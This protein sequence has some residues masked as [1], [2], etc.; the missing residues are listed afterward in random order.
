MRRNRWLYPIPFILSAIC[1]FTLLAREAVPI[2]YRWEVE[3]KL[4]FVWIQPTPPFLIDVQ[5]KFFFSEIDDIRLNAAQTILRFPSNPRLDR[6]SLLVA[7]L[8]RLNE[9]EPNLT[10]EHELLAAACLLDDG[11]RSD[12][13]WQ[14]ALKSPL[15]QR[16]V[17]RALVRWH[18]PEALSIWR[19]RIADANTP[20]HDLLLA[21]Q[22][23]GEVGTEEDI[24]SLRALALSGIQNSEVRIAAAKSIGQLGSVVDL[25]LAQK[26]RQAKTEFADYLA[27][28]AVPRGKRSNDGYPLPNQETVGFMTALANSESQIAQ[29]AAYAW[30]CELV[31]SQASEI[32]TQFI[33]SPDSELRRLALRVVATTDHEKRFAIGLSLLRDPHPEIRDEAR[34]HLRDWAE[35]SGENE[36]VLK[37]AISEELMKSDWRSLVESIRL[38]VE[39]EDDRYLDRFIDLLDHPRP[40]VG[41]AAAWGLSRLAHEHGILSKMLIHARH[42]TD[43]FKTSEKP[44]DEHHRRRVAHLLE[45]FGVERFAPAQ[46]LLME[47]VPRNDG[48]GLI[49]RIAGTWGAG[50]MWEKSDHPQLARLLCKRIADKNNPNPEYATIRYAAT[51]ALGYLADPATREDLITNDEPGGPIGYATAWAVQQ[52][53][54]P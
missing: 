29:R 15:S 54:K 16:M 30:L 34:G 51:L 10:V 46:P 31:P 8:K 38:M 4:D 50:R 21:C 49:V 19:K 28:L 9:G 48:L 39:L 40:E 45:S 14:A 3:P 12:L 37:Q 6:P 24:P 17:E 35:K 27:A 42:W 11:S 36:R 33:E 5:P 41:I 47:Y 22:G 7:I 18:R 23:I 52:L 13:L 32:S 20:V 25:P 44:V 26:L 53:D 43:V 1:Q 2:R